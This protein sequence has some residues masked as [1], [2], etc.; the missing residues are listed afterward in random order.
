MRIRVATE[1]YKKYGNNRFF[2]SEAVC[3][4]LGKF[5]QHDRVISVARDRDIREIACEI[6]R[7][8]LPGVGEAI[9]RA[10]V[11]KAESDIRDAEH[12]Q[13]CEAM[14]SALNG[15][16][17]RHDPN[18]VHFGSYGDGVNGTVEIRK[19][20]DH[21]RFEIAVPKKLAPAMAENI[22]SLGKVDVS[23]GS[24]P[25]MAPEVE[26][27][28]ETPDQ[29]LTE[30]ANDGKEKRSKLTPEERKERH[31]ALS[32]KLSDGIAELA[33]DDGRWEEFLRA[34]Q[35]FAATWSFNNIMLI[36]LQ[37][38]ER[39][40]TPSIMKTSRAWNKLGRKIKAGEKALYIFEP[41]KYRL[42]L[43]EAQKEGK[44]GFGSDGKPRMA[45]RGVRPSPRFDVS[46]TEGEP[47]PEDLAS[48]ALVTDDEIAEVWEAVAAEIRG[49]GY[50]V[51]GGPPDDVDSYTDPEALEVW[52]CDTLDDK[53]AI[54]AALRELAHIRLD[55]LDDADEYRQHRERMDREA[56][57]VAIIAAGALGLNTSPHQQP[58]LADWLEG[59]AEL[60]AE[61]A[62]RVT[63]AAQEI[64]RAL[65]EPAVPV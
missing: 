11:D 13:T 57:A 3:G 62:E 65:Q 44:K 64:I 60:L 10:R 39:G 42:S 58:A 30:D 22:S 63:T 61:T 36:L 16:T 49:S 43:E 41:M 46:Q 47:L 28:R 20:G 50:D 34:A 54:T 32:R 4:D 26:S 51:V 2:V 15:A 45:I 25:Q 17:Y 18:K 23:E 6:R 48:R 40:F 9:A 21:V 7:R 24:E 12:Q 52:V 14:A 55:H 38:A 31:D 27:E 33:E 29:V 37:A 53:A 59:D 1:H 19:F 8:L 35:G 5:V 56:S